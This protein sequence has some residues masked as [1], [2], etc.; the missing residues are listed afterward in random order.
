MG[1]ASVGV[2]AAAWI[3]AV[4]RLGG[5]VAEAEASAADLERRYAQA[6]RRYHTGTHIEAVL[7]HVAVLGAGISPRERAAVELAACAHDVVYDAVP[8]ADER[9]SADWASTA[10]ASAGVGEAV[11][12][13]VHD[14]VLLTATHTCDASDV[15]AGVLLDADLAVLAAPPEAYA[16]Y[17][18]A[19]RAEYR[20]VLDD[21]W[22]AGRAEVLRS[23]LARDRLFVTRPGRSRWE[24]A[25]RANVAGELESLRL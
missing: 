22:R 4:E 15:A 25:A 16:D 12:A 21:G 18:A 10:L 19:V 23:L 1:D 24:Q 14:L 11:A 6:H 13:R 3:A 20:T 9:A 17:V 7:G 8:G 5:R 2:V